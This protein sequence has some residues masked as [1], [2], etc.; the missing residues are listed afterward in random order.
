MAVHADPEKWE[1]S[2]SF[3]NSRDSERMEQFYDHDNKY[4]G[5]SQERMPLLVVKRMSGGGFSQYGCKLERSRQYPRRFGTVLFVFIA[6]T[7]NEK[8]LLAGDR[9]PVDND[10]CDKKNSAEQEIASHNAGACPKQERSDVQGISG[11]CV[12]A[13]VGQFTEFLQRSGADETDCFADKHH[14][15]T[16]DDARYSRTRGPD[17]PGAGDES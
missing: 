15:R 8:L 9:P 17:E 14:R 1:N 11:V 10:E 5:Y 6:V 4:A 12:Y 2:E 13:V 16:R 3:R 7:A